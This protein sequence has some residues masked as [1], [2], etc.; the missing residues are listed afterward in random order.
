MDYEY[1]ENSNLAEV[2][3]TEQVYGGGTEV[4]H[5]LYERDE[6]DRLIRIKYWGESDP[7]TIVRTE[8]NYDSRNNKVFIQDAENNTSEFVYD[9]INRLVEVK[10]HLRTDGEGEN[11][12][13]DTINTS[14][15]YDL[16]SRNTTISDDNNNTTTYAYDALNRLT[17][18]TYAIGPPITYTYDYNSNMKTLTDQNGTVIEYTYSAVD[19][20]EYKQIT[21]WGPG[22]K[23]TTTFEDYDY[24]D[25]YRLTEARNDSTTTSF[26]YDTLGRVVS[27]T[28]GGRTITR[29]FDGRGNRTQITYPGSRTVSYKPD[30]LNRIDYIYD[31]VIPPAPVEENK[32]ARY[33]YSGPGRVHSRAYNNGTELSVAYDSL[34]RVTNFDNMKDSTVISEFSYAHDLMGNRLHEKR[35]HQSKM[36]KYTYDSVYR[37]TEFTRDANLDETGGTVTTYSLDGVGNRTQMTVGG[38][39]PIDYIVNALNQYTAIEGV[40]RDHDDNGNLTDDGESRKFYF[41]YKDRLVK[42][43]DREEPPNIIAEYAYDCFGRRI[44]KTVDSVTT[45]FYYEGAS[46]IQEREGGAITAEYVY[47]AGVDEVL[48]MIRDNQSYYYHTNSLGT[49]THVTNSTGSLVEE[50]RYDA[51]GKAT[52]YDGQG[53]EIPESAIGNP[54]MFTGRRYDQETG[55]YYYRAR[56]YDPDTGR[57]IQRDNAGYIDGVNL[58]SYCHNNP[59]NRT[60]RFGWQSEEAP[61]GQIYTGEDLIK[62]I[63][64]VREKEGGPVKMGPVVG[65]YMAGR[66]GG[67]VW[68]KK[69]YDLWHKVIR[70]LS[71]SPEQLQKLLSMGGAGSALSEL[72]LEKVFEQIYKEEKAAIFLGRKARL[73]A[74]R[75]LGKAIIDGVYKGQRHG[76]YFLG[77]YTAIMTFPVW[78]IGGFVWAKM[79]IAEISMWIWG[80]GGAGTAAG[81]AAGSQATR[82][83]VT[84]HAPKVVGNILKGYVPSGHGIE[85]VI[86]REGVGVSPQAILE[87]LRYPTEVTVQQSRGGN[88]KYVG[89]NAVVIINKL[90]ELVTAWAKNSGAWRTK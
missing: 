66:P 82:Q 4:F 86:G 48:V 15:T 64:L 24:D 6:L 35:I 31:G 18:I 44:S 12:I 68:T 42:V 30:A 37:L 51:Y 1:D 27:T 45:K 16:N 76:L 52:I 43:T 79:K 49:V 2:I 20:L 74:Q 58:Y 77:G 38:G 73:A 78:G 70:L 10:E 39:D 5:T 62:N 34:K 29:E 8:W 32:F 61:D 84:R 83:R 22:V 19:L 53:Q 28:Q 17:S 13:Y 36:D 75:A 81:T 89:E 47:G 7:A 60:D 80:S 46:V 57:F 54:Y 41:D 67:V 85:R 59:I 55:L 69:S 56:Y 21:A 40:Q 71:R 11:A 26:T 23:Q 88:I 33:T 63:N 50:Y 65:D 25:L 14:Y 3:E 87:T 72:W 9:D 90:G